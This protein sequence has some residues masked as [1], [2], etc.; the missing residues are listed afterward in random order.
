MPRDG[1]GVFS[2]PAG[3]LATSNTEIE[4]AKYNAFVNDLT[5]DA[6][7]AR[8]VVAGGTGA[9][10]ASAALANFGLTATAT[11]INK[12][13]GTPAG[14]T[15]TEIG[16]LDGVTSPIQT[17][18]DGKQVSNATLTS[19]S[20]LTMVAGDLLYAT[21]SNALIRLAK[22]TAF[23]RLKMNAAATAPEW[24]SMAQGGLTST[25]SGGPYL[26]SIPPGVSRVEVLFDRISLDNTGNWFVQIGP[27]S[28]VVSTG[29]ESGSGDRVVDNAATTGFVIRSG[30]VT[31]TL[32]GRMTLILM[33]SATNLWVSDHS[34]ADTASGSM[35]SGGGRIALAGPL[36]RVRL[37]FSGGNNP[38]GGQ[39]RV[40]YE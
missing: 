27:S 17:Q 11:E 26:A 18:L 15:A 31:R 4:S 37:T 12:L 35:V 34:L 38:D 33:D 30:V 8:P 29:Y 9:T 6:N 7:T 28:G 24:D 39:F 23:Q 16:Y 13:A 14:L 3:T 36:E 19:L 5:A 25:A 2:P 1:F 21:A 22:G 20:G 40:Q 32:T 10:T